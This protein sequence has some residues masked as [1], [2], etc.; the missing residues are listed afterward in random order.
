M[1]RPQAR[2]RSIKTK[3]FFLE[4]RPEYVPAFLCSR[5][6]SNS[7]STLSLSKLVFDTTTVTHTHIQRSNL[8]PPACLPCPSL[9]Q[10][11]ELMPGG[12]RSSPTPAELGRVVVLFG[13][14]V[15]QKEPELPLGFVCSF[16]ERPCKGC[17]ARQPRYRKAK[18]HSLQGGYATRPLEGKEKQKVQ[19]MQK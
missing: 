2:G 1:A 14:Q 11:T 13:V 18:P 6:P 9:N 10:L 8:H 19:K 17:K 7:Q 12:E 4:D 5:Q 15:N 16:S 3:T